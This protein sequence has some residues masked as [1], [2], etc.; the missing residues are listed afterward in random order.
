[1]SKL[2]LLTL[3]FICPAKNFA[4]SNDN[5]VLKFSWDQADKCDLT[6]LFT[7]NSVSQE[8]TL[9]K[10]TLQI[11]LSQNTSTGDF[12][13]I[14]LFLDLEILLEMR[15]SMEDSDRD[16]FLKWNAK[17]NL[18]SFIGSECQQTSD[19]INCTNN[20][21]ISQPSLFA[22]F[23]DYIDRKGFFMQDK[24]SYFFDRGDLIV[25]DFDYEIESPNIRLFSDN[26]V[27]NDIQINA[28]KADI[29]HL[30]KFYNKTVDLSL[31]G[32]IELK[33]LVGKDVDVVLQLDANILFLNGEKSTADSVFY[34]SFFTHTRVKFETKKIS[35][36]LPYVEIYE[37]YPN[38]EKSVVVKWTNPLI[39]F[40]LVKPGN[41]KSIN[42]TS[43]TAF[44]VGVNW[45]PPNGLVDNYRINLVGNYL[46]ETK[47]VDNSTFFYNVTR[48]LQKT[49]YFVTVTALRDSLESDPKTESFET[50]EIISILNTSDYTNI[51]QIISILPDQSLFDLINVTTI[52]LQNSTNVQ[53]SLN[54]TSFIVASMAQQTK[55]STILE[56][57]INL[58]DKTLNKSNE[59]FMKDKQIGNRL[60]LSMETAIAKI[61][62][63]NSINNQFIKNYSNFFIKSKLIY[64]FTLQ[65]TGF[66]LE[67]LTENST[68][69]DD[70]LFLDSKSLN[71]DVYFNKN[72]IED[73]ILNNT[74][75]RL[76][77]IA[78]NSQKL[79][80]SSKVSELYQLEDC[81]K[82]TF[83]TINVLS[84][85]SLYNLPP[86]EGLVNII[87]PK[88]QIE[89]TCST[90]NYSLIC[91]YW[92]YDL[93]DWSS[94]G[95]NYKEL[96]KNG[97]I[98]HKCSCS[99]LSHFAILFL[100]Q[101]FKFPLH[102]EQLLFISS[103]VGISF[104]ILGLLITIL[105]EFLLII[106][107]SRF[108]KISSGVL[109][110]QR[111]M[112]KE[113]LFLFII[114]CI[115]LLIMNIIYIIFGFTKREYDFFPNRNDPDLSIT[116]CM[117]I[118][119]LLHFF[120]LNSFCLSISI[121]I[122][123]FLFIHK[124]LNSFKYLAIKS[125]VPSILIPASI[126]LLVSLINKKAY[127]RDDG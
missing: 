81:I 7:Y 61:D 98:V 41:V 26:M 37:I 100:P 48:L 79:F 97:K 19:G 30:S 119:P 109:T 56:G 31:F 15:A 94:E 58:T 11:F 117:V 55:N 86:K 9:V 1:M 108:G 35:L 6:S 74:T 62:L 90:V 123:Q 92:N 27:Q 118:G 22:K 42:F 3:I 115:S 77:F 34:E 83:L 76:S 51:D 66:I 70:E 116:K 96:E 88:Q 89:K 50:L 24:V 44:S 60:S 126:V 8:C 18:F 106:N 49:K 10:D 73:L 71:Y 43:I 28:N 63:E 21:I 85:S 87:F 102:L 111:Q 36:K 127:Y 78:Y 82:Q 68:E 52:E 93:N 114:W 5:F 16:I 32:Y 54:K 14:D 39:D 17:N 75:P 12:K 110:R 101:N 47:I 91:V 57:L 2:L 67:G 23:T 65:D 125:L 29:N 40:D 112:I 72:S 59:I 46:S 107:P 53:D 33:S 84:A 95:C 124:S 120:L 80:K 104:S 45:N 38:S 103:I 69:I 99:H 105:N 64:N 113:Y 13:P 122:I 20:D 121:S 4:L 25:R